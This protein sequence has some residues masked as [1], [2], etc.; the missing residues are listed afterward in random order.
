MKGKPIMKTDF[1]DVDSKLTVFQRF[2]KKLIECDEIIQQKNESLKR[3]VSSFVSSFNT[4]PNERSE[5]ELFLFLRRVYLVDHFMLSNE[6]EQSF[7]DW[8]ELLS[9]ESL[10]IHFDVTFK[11]IKSDFE[12]KPFSFTKL[13]KEFIRFGE[14][15]YNFPVDQTRKL[16]IFNLLDYNLLIQN[17]DD[18]DECKENDV[19]DKYKDELEINCSTRNETSIIRS[20]FSRKNY[21]SVL[22]FIGSRASLLLVI[23]EGEVRTLT[24]PLFL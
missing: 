20:K 5:K 23:N 21:P 1:V 10:S 11:L 15:P 22:L 4:N 19:C 12:F 2:I 9:I 14:A 7:I 18:F 24:S 8:D 16:S 13:P 3:I 17:Y 6:E